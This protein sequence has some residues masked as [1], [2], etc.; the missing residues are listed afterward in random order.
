MPMPLLDHFGILAPFYEHF[1]PPREP[2]AIWAL[3]DLP[4]SGAL[5]DAGGGT[6]RVAQFLRGLAAQVV[7]ADLSCK[8]LR[9]ARKKD[10][11]HPVCSYTEKLPFLDESFERV[12][13]VDALHHVHDQRQTVGELWRVLQPGGRI[14][15]EEPDVR[16]FVAK[17]IAWGERLALMRSHFLSPSQIAGLFGYPN[18]R[19]RIQTGGSNVWVV[20]EKEQT[21]TPRPD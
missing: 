5:L 20:V 8:M 1:I 7:V 14:V 17:L 18:A 10:G 15:I 9:E 12:I 11:L 6:G 13:M 4:I 2:Q 16:T 21:R 3:A 19:V